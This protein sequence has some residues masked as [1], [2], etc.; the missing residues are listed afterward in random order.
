MPMNFGIVMKRLDEK[1]SKSD[2]TMPD[3]LCL[4]DYTSSWNMDLYLA[5]DKEIADA[6]TPH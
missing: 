2:A 4:S 1:L 5:V 6:K 3:Y